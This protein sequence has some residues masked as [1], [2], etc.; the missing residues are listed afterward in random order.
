MKQPR[1]RQVPS[2]WKGEL[3]LNVANFQVK[4]LGGRIQQHRFDT[5][6]EVETEILPDN[7][8]LS[9][10]FQSGPL[11]REGQGGT[12]LGDHVV[13]FDVPVFCFFAIIV[14]TGRFFHCCSNGS[15]PTGGDG[16]LCLQP[17]HPVYAAYFGQ[18]F[19]PTG[20]VAVLSVF[21]QNAVGSQVSQS[22]QQRRRTVE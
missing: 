14:K 5:R 22:Q 13:A 17:A 6:G 10:I 2:P 8:D 20:V 21:G 15:L 18:L 4:V 12:Q 19:Q 7:L 9:P 11:F 16:D 3:A 1:G